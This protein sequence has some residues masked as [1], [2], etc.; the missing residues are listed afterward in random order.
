MRKLEPGID[1]KRILAMFKEALAYGDTT[2]DSIEPEVLVDLIV[3]YKVGGYG[4]EFFSQY[5]KRKYRKKESKSK[6]KSLKRPPSSRNL[7]SSLKRPPSS[8]NLKVRQ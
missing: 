3:R 8:R 4:K 6:D 2:M 7:E 5:L 1:K